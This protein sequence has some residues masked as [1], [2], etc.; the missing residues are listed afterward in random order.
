MFDQ[1]NMG[2]RGFLKGAVALGLGVSG[3]AMMPRNAFAEE[4]KKGGNLRLGLSGG[5]PTDAIDPGSLINTVAMFISYTFANRLVEIAPNMMPEPELAES[6][7]MDESATRWTINLR[8]GV[9]FHNGKEMTADDV[10]YSL[11]LHMGPDSKSA[12]RAQAAEISS[13]KK[14]SSH[15]IEIS[16]FA[17]NVDFAYRLADRHFY[18]VPEGFS[19][20]SKP[21]ST[22][23][24]VL[25]SYQSGV[26][27]FGTRNKNY[28]RS[29]RAHVDS[30]EV[31]VLND[32]AARMNAFVSGQV[33]AINW[34]EPKMLP[35][36]GAGNFEI[37]RTPGDRHGL[38][39]MHT[40]MKPFSDPNVRLALKHAIDREAILNTVYMG[41]G[42][43]G[44]DQP[45]DSHHPFYNEALQQHSYDPD[46]AKHYLKQANID[47]LEVDLSVSSVAFSGSEEAALVFQQ[48]AKAAGIA[49]RV[50]RVPADG[51]W[52]GVWLKAPFAAGSWQSRPSANDRFAVCYQSTAAWNE[53]HWNNPLFDKLLL[54]AR[55]ERDVVRRRAMYAE[56]QALVHQDGGA[57]IPVFHDYLDAVSTRVK[58]YVTNPY[59]DLC[60]QQI[61]E[62]V[63][64]ES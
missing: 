11:Q 9:L 37:M 5:G 2:R 28:W 23:P 18:I 26:R 24:Y 56:M 19:D 41:Y 58:G 16:L 1:G 61:A 27:A 44:N 46:K 22:G 62:L 12:V 13:L 30:V 3:A 17:G 34:L 52:D 57:I 51:Y 63:W 32:S 49:V 15:Q 55:T 64:L 59:G 10:I 50:N 42:R 20:W 48:N 8:K 36:L 4:P 38:F 25:E 40:Q 21:I 7:E 43:I 47:S 31:I 45:I 35:M 33:D 53:T 6:W 60:G 54:E 39:A 14:L 29:D